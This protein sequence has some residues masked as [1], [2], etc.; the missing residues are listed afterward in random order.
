LRL[1]KNQRRFTQIPKEKGFEHLPAKWKGVVQRATEKSL[2]KALDFA[3]QTM[4]DR[5]QFR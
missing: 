3:I 4:N 2:E 1:I 5:T